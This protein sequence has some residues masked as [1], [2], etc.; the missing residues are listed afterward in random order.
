MLRPPMP[1]L[2][3]GNFDFEGELR[4][5]RRTD[6]LPAGRIARALRGVWLSMAE[7]GDVVIGPDDRAWQVGEPVAAD[8]VELS[9]APSLLPW[10][11][12]PSPRFDW[13]PWGWSQA[14]VTAARGWPARVAAP[15]LEAVAQVNRRSFRARLELE[16]GLAPAGLAIC[17]TP[18]DVSRALA[19]IHEN[20]Y[21]L[22]STTSTT[23]ADSS[24][25]AVSPRYDWVIKAEYGMAGRQAIR[26]G[27]PVLSPRDEN[28]LAHRLKESGAVVVEPWLVAA[29]E[30][31]LQF[32][33]PLD[34]EPRLRGMTRQSVDATG[35]Y[36]GSLAGRRGDGSSIADRYAP[37]LPA[38]LEIARRVQAAGYAG[39]LG[40]DVMEY[41]AAD[42]SRAIRVLQDLNARYSMGYLA[43][44]ASERA[45]RAVNWSPRASEAELLPPRV[46]AAA[47]DAATE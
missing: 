25:S 17:R 39:P 24:E 11:P 1:R 5:G 16:L 43:L 34:G 19:V 6:D 15:P 10:T 26:G 9:P 45:G 22:S 33:L 46:A 37:A 36:R 20:R 32:D 7:P 12:R 14:A 41:T 3:L 27:G 29:S 47:D 2:F 42:G 30:G 4:L 18:A 8:S 38:G 44:V 23:S 28:W 31:S 40:I 13:T 35:V 21:T